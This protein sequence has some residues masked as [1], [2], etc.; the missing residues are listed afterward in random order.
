MAK[1]LIKIPYYIL[2]DLTDYEEETYE[3]LGI[4]Q[5]IATSVI[6][7]DLSLVVRMQPCIDETMPGT[8]VEFLDGDSVT[9]PVEFDRMVSA[10]EE[11]KVELFISFN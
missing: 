8:C 9:T 3:D 11:S 5:E 7:I 10:W 4:P 2:P 1:T 6:V